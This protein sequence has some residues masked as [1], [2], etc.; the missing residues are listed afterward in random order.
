MHSEEDT[1]DE[2][3]ESSDGDAPVRIGKL[4]DLKT[5]SVQHTALRQELQSIS[6]GQLVAKSC[7]GVRYEIKP[8]PKKS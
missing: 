6:H 7:V 2:S 8:K 5:I 4:S 3:S 1:S